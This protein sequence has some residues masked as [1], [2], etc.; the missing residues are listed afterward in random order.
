MTGEVLIIGAKGMDFSYSY[1]VAYGH[2]KK[3]IPE[4]ITFES[5]EILFNYVIYD[6]ASTTKDYKS[7]K[8]SNITI[9]NNNSDVSN[10][11]FSYF[12]NGYYVFLSGLNIN[13]KPYT[14]DYYKKDIA[15][16]TPYTYGVD[17]LG[18]W[19]GGG[20]T[21]NKLIPQY[22][23]SQNGDFTIIGTS[24]NPSS[25]LFDA[26]LLSKVTYPTKG[27]S[28]FVYEPHQYSKK[29]DR[30]ASSDFLPVLVNQ[31][32]TIGGARIKK[33][34]DFDG[35]QS[36][37]REYKYIKNLLPNSQTTESSGISNSYVRFFELLN[38][39]EATPGNPNGIRRSSLTETA[40]NMVLSTYTNSP[41]NYT[42]VTELLNNRFNKKFLFSGLDTDPD[43]LTIRK[44]KPYSSTSNFNP[45]FLAEN[46]AVR[47]NSQE[48]YRNSLLKTIFYKD[49]DVVKEIENK[50]TKLL[51]TN[52]FSNYYYSSVG[53]KGDW[54][55]FYK[56]FIYPSLLSSTI[57]REYLNGSLI[58][59]KSEYLYENSSDNN[60]TKQNTILPDRTLT[61]SY[62][63]A[64]NLGKQYLV[65]KNILNVPLVTENIETQNNISKTISKTE[66]AYP[67]SIADA[68]S[69]NVDDK[70]R[71]VP[72]D[73]FN[74]DIRSSSM[75]NE[76]KYDKYDGNGNP[77]QYTSKLGIPT[78][79]IWGYNNT[80]PIAKIEGATYPDPQNP[81]STD[82][83][84]SLMTTLATASDADAALAPR[85]D[86]STFLM[87]L[88]T[89]RNDPSLMSYQI[90]TF[91]YDPLIGVR[92]ITSPNG[93]TEFYK[94]DN[95]NKL[96]RILDKD[97]NIIK[98]FKYNYAPTKFYN[99]RQ[100]RKIYK[101]DCPSWQI[102]G[103]YNYVVPAGIYFSYVDVATAN[104][105]AIAEINQ[106]GQQTANQNGSCEF[107]S[108]QLSPNY[109]VALQGYN[110]I[111]ET[112]PNHIE[113][114]L[115]F[116]ADLTGL[117]MSYTSGS[118][119]S[120]GFIGANCRPNSVK[121]INQ[122][123]W[124]ITVDTNGYVMIRS[125]TG[126][127]PP[128]NTQVG[129]SFSY[130]K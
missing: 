35:L 106:N 7:Y 67:A 36:V 25:T 5:S 55:Y 102:G 10:I 53:G 74:M 92:S 117:G 126:S 26:T 56:E 116:K 50:Y 8:L 59:T 96:E 27:F 86:E 43:T 121:V 113:V 112:Q 124:T 84:K 46:L 48:S 57:T 9:K 52:R 78:T 73:L 90:T 14:F 72:F 101:N 11:D 34:I 44:T 40:N 97:N 47:Y 69:R 80:Q 118:G 13:N 89:F 16:P 58:N 1:S 62:L 49:N 128:N 64:R 61:K 38:Y 31:I 23:I 123:N 81:K 70:D 68:K 83:S 130:D 32:G 3:V 30:N 105:M 54:I 12:R 120:V 18:Y 76:I 6:R 39:S 111:Q 77:V 93:I 51:S 63:Y 125:N 33:I 41:I 17:F 98:E 109:Y 45:P 122:T 119:V 95:E 127:A 4:R 42:E 115:V 71:P 91:T 110:S 20:E 82:I 108:C 107:L 79:I 22:Q 104:Q 129:V 60:L 85:S 66:I 15:L 75:S 94:Y 2:V 19:N 88:N 28:E 103:A 37:T 21:T 65:D 24:R 114:I 100:E 29:I 99:E 87:A